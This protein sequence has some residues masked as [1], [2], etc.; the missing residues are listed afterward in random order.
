MKGTNSSSRSRHKLLVLMGSSESV[1]AQSGPEISSSTSSTSPPSSTSSSP[2]AG[3]TDGDHERSSNRGGS[4]N[5]NDNNS[6]L[7]NMP[8]IPFGNDLTDDHVQ[9][10]TTLSAEVSCVDL[11]DEPDDDASDMIIEYEGTRTGQR[12]IKHRRRDHR[13]NPYS[14]PQT[15]AP[16]RSSQD[17]IVDLS[18]S[19]SPATPPPSTSSRIE[20]RE[21][22][23]PLTRCPIPFFNPHGNIV[24]K[25]PTPTPEGN[26]RIIKCSIC[27]EDESTIQSAGGQIVSTV[28]GHVFCKEC[29]VKAIKN[30]R[31]CPKCRK[32]LSQKQFHPIFF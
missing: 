21:L 24:E 2:S 25:P 30:Q 7:L 10:S 26:A 29:I 4:D 20:L 8:I 22:S 5:N 32:K 16:I 1:V 15:F 9:S 13:M 28:C 31:M 17:V 27:L 6:R 19:P 11:T 18:D 12:P 23:I 3:D 14:R